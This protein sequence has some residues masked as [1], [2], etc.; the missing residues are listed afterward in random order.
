MD[1]ISAL[2]EYL[3]TAVLQ[4]IV[5]YPVFALILTSAILGAVCAFLYGKLLPQRAL[6]R[7]KQGIAAQ[8]LRVL[9]FRRDLRAMLFAQANLL[10]GGVKY[11][12]V[13]VPPI[14]VLLVPMIFVLAELNLWFGF[15]PAPVNSPMIVE[16]QLRSSS[17]RAIGGASVEGLN[18]TL[19]SPPVRQQRTGLGT[20]SVTPQ[21][22]QGGLIAFKL[23]DDRVSF[24]LPTRG[25]YSSE[26]LRRIVPI[27]S[28]DLLTSLLNPPGKGGPKIPEVFDNIR[29]DYPARQFNLLGWHTGWMPPFFI[30]T[31]LFGYLMA[32]AAKIEV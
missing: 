16:A 21:S 27:Y 1:R 6:K 25:G 24:T 20:W 18:D 13:S 11:L 28:S 26:S 9:V 31:V 17:V 3:V 30:L 32:R 2:V 19:V 8:F 7:V 10:L 29:L 4:P 15:D 12:L 23:G 5:A 14:A 22:T